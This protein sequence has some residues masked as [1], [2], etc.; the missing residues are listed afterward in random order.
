M[1][2]QLYHYPFDRGL[3]Q[4]KDTAG[5]EQPVGLLE[6]SNLWHRYTGV[7]STRPGTGRAA[8]NPGG[9]ALP[10]EAVEGGAA[11]A[12]GT[13]YLQTRPPDG[14]SPGWVN[15]GHYAQPLP[16]GARD[17]GTRIDVT[18]DD[19]IVRHVTLWKHA[20]L[21][22]W[23]DGT[24]VYVGIYH[25]DTGVTLRE[26][27]FSGGA[28]PGAVIGWAD[29][30]DMSPSLYLRGTT[31]GVSIR[32]ITFDDADNFATTTANMTDGI[33]DRAIV[34]GHAGG[35]AHVAFSTGP[36]RYYATK[37]DTT[38]DQINPGMS[39]SSI[40]SCFS[41]QGLA[42]F[43]GHATNTL[44]VLSA[45]G[46]T[47]NGISTATPSDSG[48]T[49]PVIVAIGVNT[50]AVFLSAATT[51]ASVSYF[52]VT[53]PAPSIG[54]E[55]A[56]YLRQAIVL[57]GA[58]FDGNVPYVWAQVGN[59]TT[60][61]SAKTVLIIGT[62]A[63]A[64][65]SRLTV[66]AHSGVMSVATIGRVWPAS[67]YAPADEP[68]P[69]AWVTG[70][71]DLLDATD[72]TLA[73]C[74]AL[75]FA[76]SGT[77][78]T[79][80]FL[81]RQL[82]PGGALTDVFGDCSH[83]LPQ[84][85]PAITDDDTASGSLSAGDYQFAA[86]H[87]KRDHDGT[88]R[89]GAVSE[90]YTVTVSAGTGVE[91]SI[92]YDETLPDGW[93]IAIYRTIADGS[94]KYFD[95]L[96]APGATYTSSQGDA[97]LSNNRTLYTE[98][99]VLSNDAA[100]S[101]RFLAVGK[102]RAWLGGLAQKFR[103]RF[104]KEG[105]RGET[106]SFPDDPSHWLD[107]GSDVTAL[108]CI[109]D[110]ALAF[111]RDSVDL[112]SGDG[113]DAR[114]S[115]S[116][117]VR[118]V[119]VGVGADDWRSVVTTPVGVFF[120]GT[121]SIWLMGRGFAAPENVGALVRDALADYPVVLA[122]MLVDFGHQQCVQFLCSDDMTGTNTT[123]LVF[124]LRSLQWY[125]WDSLDATFLGDVTVDGARR[126]VLLP[127]TFPSPTAALLVE[128]ESL[129]T[130]E[131]VTDDTTTIVTTLQTHQM[132]MWG[133]AADA[134]VRCAFVR[135]KASET[136]DWELAF[137]VNGGLRSETKTFQPVSKPGYQIARF[138]MR[139]Q[140]VQSLGIQLTAGPVALAGVMVEFEG[141]GAPKLATSQK[142][143]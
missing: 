100:P 29:H 103:V 20:Q 33:D 115:G 34:C 135:Y 130:D 16:L 12:G 114:G 102:N 46:G 3:D 39:M 60:N 107:L 9:S 5:S 19:Y 96:T 119:T 81:D 32:R 123:R 88:I 137:E 48:K 101:H 90:L 61:L 125:Q 53:G 54:T 50:A 78:R 72:N 52:G 110:V 116:F 142:R 113:P 55:D 68:F 69:A 43:A 49:K 23:T 25:R 7:L 15:G 13:A 92:G 131:Q 59:A 8:G 141:E 83:T 1:A 132:H 57:G 128:S 10:A 58:V 56:D 106:P 87:Y 80:R 28:V 66:L 6:C 45:N 95:G 44:Y 98:G 67:G 126:T 143:G 89:E 127:T 120:A 104:S 70:L 82:I 24:T 30:G 22:A 76:M 138:G 136:Q 47:S 4:S 99:G 18:S 71:Y 26:T 74:Q 27:T 111:H 93:E 11:L 35:A 65:T 117:T 84:T 86:V 124:S 37:A 51:D 14:E 97:T 85:Y 17:V 41:Y 105:V 139:E 77:R 64:T 38:A 36:I 31:A 91:L 2:N 121:G 108:A 118:P 21:A 42:W 40:V 75:T 140:D 129:T 79:A 109:D 94:T 73:Q 133:L 62:V 134:R 122:A 63:S 112:I